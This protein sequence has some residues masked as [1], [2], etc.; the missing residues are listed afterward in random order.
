M[1]FLI[2]DD[3]TLIRE[4][5]RLIVQGMDDQ[6]DIHEAA[7]GAQALAILAKDSEFDL[8]LLDLKLPD[9]HG[10]MLLRSISDR[11][12]T[13]P[14]AVISAESDAH[15]VQR[16]LRLGAAGYIPKNALNQ[17]LSSAIRLILEGGIYVPP[18]ALT[19]RRDDGASTLNQGVT[20]ADL[21]LTPRQC[22]VLVLL[23]EGKTNKEIC[24]ALNLAEATVKVHVR[25]IL[26]ALAVNSR[27]EAVIAINRLGL[28]PR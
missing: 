3:H 6:A 14:V 20:P 17:V 26:R 13:V 23:S 15:T 19:Q 4:G 22:E 7:S 24:R 12:P 8:I 28:R 2:C 18:E 25:A 10:E 9:V 21:G 5:L 11:Y 16:M 1:R 27:T